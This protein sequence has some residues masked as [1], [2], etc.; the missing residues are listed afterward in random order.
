MLVGEVASGKRKTEIKPKEKAHWSYCICFLLLCNKV[1][2]TLQFKTTQIYHLIVSVAQKSGHNSLVPLFKAAIKVSAT[3]ILILNSGSS[4]NCIWLLA[5]FRIQLLAGIG[6][7][8]S[9]F[10]DHPYFPVMWCSSWAIYIIAACL[11]EVIGRV[12]QV[13]ANKTEPYMHV[14]R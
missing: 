4:S 10:R 5:E 11:F 8:P 6:L 12:S 7:R 14:G 2:Q 9:V 3:H 1:L 13:H